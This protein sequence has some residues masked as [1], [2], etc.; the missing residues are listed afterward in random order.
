MVNG[1][2]GGFRLWIKFI[3]DNDLQ[4][5]AGEFLQNDFAERRLDHAEFAWNRETHIHLLTRIDGGDFNGDVV[6]AFIGGGA[7]ITSHAFHS[8]F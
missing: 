2:R 4:R 5:A 8:I 6:A 7:S 3:G 1:L